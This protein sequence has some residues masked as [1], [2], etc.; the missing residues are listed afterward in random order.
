MLQ[1]AGTGTRAECSVRVWL[2]YY[3]KVPM[4]NTTQVTLRTSMATSK[5][6]VGALLVDSKTKEAGKPSSAVSC[7]DH[8]REE[9]RIWDP[10]HMPGMCATVTATCQRLDRQRA[11]LLSDSKRHFIADA[12][13]LVRLQSC[14]G[15]DCGVKSRTRR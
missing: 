13:S 8:L 10:F 2:Q 15:P 12:E 5:W 6:Y 3:L 7:S 11:C 14:G 4:A 9:C 1:R